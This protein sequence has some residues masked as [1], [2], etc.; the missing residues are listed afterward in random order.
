MSAERAANARPSGFQIGL[1]RADDFRRRQ[2]DERLD[3]HVLGMFTQPAAIVSRR[4]AI[5]WRI[6]AGT[7][8]ESATISIPVS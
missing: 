4:P 3:D 7:Q 6:P 8:G 2:H 1:K 5:G